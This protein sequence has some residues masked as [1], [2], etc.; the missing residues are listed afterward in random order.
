MRYMHTRYGVYVRVRVCVRVRARY[1]RSPEVHRPPAK[2]YCFSGRW[3]LWVTERAPS[4]VAL[5]VEFVV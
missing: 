1:G 5:R 2:C 4:E 3:R